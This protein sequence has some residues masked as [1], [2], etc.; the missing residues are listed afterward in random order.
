MG[1]AFEVALIYDL[2]PNLS[3][4]IVD[5]LNYL[6]RSQDYDF[7]AAI[8]HPF[9]EIEFGE[10]WRNIIANHHPR[11]GEE[12]SAQTH[13]SSLDRNQLCFRV[14]L[15]DDTFFNIGFAFLDWLALLSSTQGLVGYYIDVFQFDCHLIYFRNEQS[16]ERSSNRAS[17]PADLMQRIDT[18]L[19]G[20]S[21]VSLTT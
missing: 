6:T 21:L 12:D 11:T 2:K 18:R 3:P 16:I 5:T 20:S 14:L 1:T 13:R 8:E 15:D 17:I 19:G 4:Q 10:E 7:D 9:F